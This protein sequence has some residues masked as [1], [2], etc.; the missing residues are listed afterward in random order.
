[1][2]LLLLISMFHRLFSTGFS[3]Y[4]TQNN[5]LSIQ[6]GVD[7][8]TYDLGFQKYT[9]DGYLRNNSADIDTLFMR[10]GYVMPSEGYVTLTASYTDADR[11]TPI[12]NDPDNPDTAYDSDYPK[13]SSSSFNHWAEPTWDKIATSYRLDAL[14]SSVLGTW[15]ASA[16]YSE[17]NR[18]RSYYDWVSEKDH[19]KGIADA[20]WDTIWKQ[21][22]GKVQN[23][24]NVAE[25]HTSTFGMELEQCFDGYGRTATWSD[26]AHDDEKRIDILAGFVQHKWQLFPS[27]SLTGGLRYENVDIKVSNHSSSS[28]ETYITGRSMWID[29][30]FE[31]W[32]PKSWI[33]YEL[34]Q[35]GD[36]L[37]D[38]SVSM[39]V[40][41]IWR[42]PDYHGDYNPQGR[43]AG[44]W[45]EPEHGVGCDFVLSRRLFKD[46]N[47][48]FNYAWYNINDYIATNNS[49]AKYTPGSDNAVTPGL[50][51]KDYKINLD[52]VVRHG[53]E[54]QLSGHLTDSLSFMA[55]YAWQ[56]F[57]SKG[58]EPAG[59]TELDNRAEHRVNA[60]LTWN[61]LKD[62]ALIVN[63]EFQD[64]QII[65]KSDE[66]APDQWKFE[67]MAVDAYHRVDLAVEHT[68]FQK[69]GG[70]S[71]SNGN[72]KGKGVVKFYVGNIFDE[73][74]EDTDGFPATDR[75]F[76]VGFTLDI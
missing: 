5:S 22:G 21:R 53:I 6:G 44:A 2:S 57:E 70:L 68:L 40:S 69:W 49:Y 28:G 19:S 75:T 58:D 7:A 38:T 8:F 20:S 12:N 56:R 11:K 72:G 67:E 23:E 4:A 65:E 73:T 37:R 46:I 59:E 29:R 74:Y 39:G 24:L 31:G 32:L 47:M 14:V 30:S 50:E 16:F 76:G 9:T 45:L 26:I 25:N 66:V 71:K 17:E 35:W 36:W 34:D 18:D 64:D 60:G 3:S 43:P 33:N 52:R 41:R 61:F 13:V 48:K 63:Y 10:L 1:M 55:G 62:T 15:K 54:W 51:Y 27:L 42:A